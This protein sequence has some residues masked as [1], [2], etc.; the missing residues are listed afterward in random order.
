MDQSSFFSNSPNKIYEPV[1]A[2]PATDA[3]RSTV[4]HRLPTSFITPEPEKELTRGRLFLHLLLL[5]L[6]VLTTTGIGLLWFYSDQ[7]SNTLSR[8]LAKGIVYS[9]TII[10]ILA[11]HE[12]GH[13]IACRW[14]GVRATLPYF[15]P[16]PFPPIGT[17]G[18]FIKIK[19]PIPTR[20]A[21]FDIGIAGPLA[22]F[23]FA[24]PAA[25]VAHYFAIAAYTPAA[26]DSEGGFIINTP[27]L[28]QL[29][30]RL[31]HLPELIENNP[32]WWAAWVGVFMT[33]LNLV[34]VGQLDGG[35]VTFAVFG[36]RG[37]RLVA[38]ACYL[39]VIGLAIYSGLYNHTWTWVV[40]GVILTLMLRVGH[41]PVVDNREPLGFARKLVA[42]IGL[43]VFILSFIPVPF[44]FD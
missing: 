39:A 1:P 29:F 37:H 16:V 28:F 21:L 31:F 13:Y 36:P 23:I 15:I 17:F 41:P 24:V 19:S 43:I 18:A 26:A 4:V 30:E 20:R 34:P 33:S 40:Y 2:D 3:N 25:F 35:H 22:G 42:I 44:S 5:G 10:T 7:S 11:A 12:M 14:Y 9:F 32:V 38:L 6:T 27:L 8:G